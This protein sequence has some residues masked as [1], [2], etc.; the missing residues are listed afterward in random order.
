MP[1][2]REK[3]LRKKKPAPLE[4]KGAAPARLNPE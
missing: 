1:S 4:T 3:E 2:H